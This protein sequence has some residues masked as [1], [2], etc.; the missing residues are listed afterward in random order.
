MQ[1]DT[2]RVIKVKEKLKNSHPVLK[3]TTQST[4]FTASGTDF[5]KIALNIN[6]KGEPVPRETE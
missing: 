2:Y 6:E 3:A 4:R 1:D 5:D